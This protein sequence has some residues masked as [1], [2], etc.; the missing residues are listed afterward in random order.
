MTIGNRGDRNRGCRYASLLRQITDSAFREGDMQTR[1]T[2][3]L[4]DGA[5]AGHDGYQIWL[6]SNRH[7]NMTVG[8]EFAAFAA[9]VRYA[10]R[11]LGW[12]VTVPPQDD[13]ECEQR[14]SH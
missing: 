2:T 1:D 14:D 6:G 9:L 10:A 11:T 3:H 8:L 5:Y 12:R 4:G 7:E 13:C